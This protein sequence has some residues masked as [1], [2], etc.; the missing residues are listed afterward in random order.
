MIFSTLFSQ[1]KHKNGKFSTNSGVLN[2]HI[3][4]PTD[5]KMKLV[6]NSHLREPKEKTV[7]NPLIPIV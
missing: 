7:A 6:W 5:N 4:P 2:N 3:D 1:W